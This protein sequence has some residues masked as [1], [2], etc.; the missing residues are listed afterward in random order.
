[1]SWARLARAAR[2]ALGRRLTWWLS[3]V[4]A[5][6]AVGLGIVNAGAEGREPGISA[7]VITY[8]DPDWLDLALRGASRIADEVVVIDSSD[9]PEALSVLED[10][11][12][13]L[14]VIVYRQY[15]P[16]GYAEARQ[17]GLRRTT[18]R[19]VLVWDSDFVPYPEAAGLIRG[20]AEAH[21]GRA[22]YM[23]Y[24]PYLN[25]CGDTWHRCRAD[26]FHVEHWMFTYSRRLR[27]LWDG[28][29][30]YLLAPPH[31]FRVMLSE[32]PLGV[33]LSGVRRPD[34][35][36]FK[37]LAA[38]VGFYAIA[39]SRGYN[40]ARRAVREEARRLYGTDDLWEV[41]VRMIREEV[42][43]RPCASGLRVPEEVRE[44]ARRL[45]IPEEPC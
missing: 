28:R 3:D 42:R 11:K 36:A 14:G 5:A 6:L 25:L 18:R 15:P 4:G 31:Y 32:E 26:R 29:N 1:L 38:R 10:A 20:F 17:E 45:G 35:K 13:G 12:S 44:R 30:E 37:A 40:E 33:H 2:R 27:Y 7:M 9:D 21:S 16:R 41:G 24:W 19:F 43:S 39:A 22:Y 23:V 34:R 8:N